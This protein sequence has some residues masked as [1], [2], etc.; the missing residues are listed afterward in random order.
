MG[1]SLSL[2][3][4]LPDIYVP[5]FEMTVNGVPLPMNVAKSV[6]DIS[7]MQHL[8]PPNSFQFRLYDPK[9][10]LADPVTG[11]FTEGSRIEISLG[12]VGN[13][14]KLIVGEITA[15]NAD[16]PNSGPPALAVEGM[17]MINRMMRGTTYRRFDGPSPDTGLAD[18]EIIS[19]VIAL[20]A[21]LAP[22]VD[23]TGQR[24][25]A[26]VQDNVSNFAFTQQ[27]AGWDGYYFWVDGD[28]FYFKQ[29]RPAPNNLTL[30]WGRTLMSFSARL[31]TAGQ[32]QKAEVRGW[33]PV[34]K[35]QFSVTAERT[36]SSSTLS[37]TGQ[38]QLAK[39]SG[40]QSSLL[41]SDAPVTS[42]SEAQAYAQAIID[43]QQQGLITGSGT[44]VGQPDMQVG[45]LLQVMGVG[46]FSRKY[47]VQQATHTISGSGY[48]TSFE[49]VG[50]PDQS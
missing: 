19:T 18:S 1:L 27:L 45:T 44:S 42:A 47:T 37:S 43:N 38:T 33:D 29:Q 28:T 25:E 16:F 11:L 4:I 5:T 13:T 35:Q 48:Q 49:V 15:L 40:G 36:D 14:K 50:A 22:N 8:M 9:M 3:S 17:D 12:F 24:T 34:Q 6:M 32:V 26:R 46:R 2:N 30:E 10:D 31:S 39:G 21:D 41:I 23:D 7:V 20:E